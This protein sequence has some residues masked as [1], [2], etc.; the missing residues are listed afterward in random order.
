MDESMLQRLCTDDQLGE[1]NDD[2]R[3]LL[4]AYLELK[5]G[6]DAA[7]KATQHV[8]H[9]AETALRTGK[10]SADS[11]PPLRTTHGAHV[12]IHMV[13]RAFGGLA[14][15]A[16]LMLAFWLGD[17]QAGRRNDLFYQGAQSVTQFSTPRTAGDFWSVK[18]FSAAG[19]S[20]SATSTT[21]HW[22]SPIEKPEMRS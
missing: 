8:L 2:T 15:A 17:R 11:L 12:R 5:P 4:S 21:L 6:A 7:T 18:N 13:K 1:L 20:K 14:I 22:K 16:S 19:S 3:A 10:E 9:L